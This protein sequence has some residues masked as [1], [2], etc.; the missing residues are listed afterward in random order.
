MI[1]DLDGKLDLMYRA[2]DN[3]TSEG[4]FTSARNYFRSLL[5]KQTG[6]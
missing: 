4:S 6:R 3:D 5:F 1:D 2:I